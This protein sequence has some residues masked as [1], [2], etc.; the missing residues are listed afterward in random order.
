MPELQEVKDYYAKRQR[1][2][3]I[4]PRK[5]ML[6]EKVRKYIYGKKVLDYG[7]GD[8]F[9]TACCSRFCNIS[10]CDLDSKIALKHFPGIKFF[11]I[12]DIQERY[13]VIMLLDVLEHI[14]PEVSKGIL[15]TLCSVTDCLILNIPEVK[16]KEQIVE[17]DINILDLLY[18]L[19][20]QGM[21]LTFFERWC[22]FTKEVYRFMVLNAK[23]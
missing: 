9:I 23:S 15:W 7:C 2:I 19:D 6:L 21:E 12:K 8:G 22:V 16:K 14:E 10:G 17:Y 5:L 18:F 13:D 3:S 1:N 11:D 20:S 4:S